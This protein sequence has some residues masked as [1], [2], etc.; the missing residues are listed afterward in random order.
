MLS[1]GLDAVG[2]K[3]AAGRCQHGPLPENIAVPHVL[4]SIASFSFSVADT[5]HFHALSV[6]VPGRRRMDEPDVFAF[7]NQIVCGTEGQ[8][9]RLTN[10]WQVKSGRT[11]VRRFQ[12]WHTIQQ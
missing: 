5:A 4:G 10:S 8:D 2:Q 11:R 1:H 12:R 6:R 9:C 3:R 7:Q